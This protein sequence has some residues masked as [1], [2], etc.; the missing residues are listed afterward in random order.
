LMNA[1]W[2]KSTLADPAT[3]A[4]AAFTQSLCQK[5]YSPKP[6]GTF[7]PI[8]EFANNKLAMFG[9]GMWLNPSIKTANA[10]GKVK[11]V[12][13]PKKTTMGTSVGWN[14]Y[15]I[16][17]K[18]KNKE[19]AWAFVKYLA[20]KRAVQNLASTGQ[21]T[22]GRKSIFFNN[23]PAAAPEQGLDE[24]W[25]SVDYATPV[26]SPDASDAVNGAIIKALTQLYSSNVDPTQLFTSLDKEVTG[27]L[28]ASSKGG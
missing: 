19:A 21:A 27:Y 9:C 14:A 12:S 4:A 11:I 17:E 7:D 6:G 15:P 23:L 20:S 2:S 28:T 3:I 16:M 24:L 18:S 8:A 22:P 25:N 26:P 10:S 13:W 1:D 5:G